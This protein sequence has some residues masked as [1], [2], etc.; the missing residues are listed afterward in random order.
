MLIPAGGVA[1]DAYSAARQPILPAMG[2]LLPAGSLATDNRLGF[3]PDLRALAEAAER[4]ELAWIP[5]VETSGARSAD[6]PHASLPFRYL[7]DGRTIPSW[8]AHAA[9]IRGTNPRQGW[10][11]LPS[12]ATFVD[13]DSPSAEWSAELVVEH[14]DG[15]GRLA[16][17]FP[18]T[19]TGR[20]LRD[21]VRLMAALPS[22]RL[23]I[24]CVVSGF[25][26]HRDQ[27]DRESVLFAEVS[28][29]VI[30][31]QQG[32]REINAA[33]RAI[34][35]SDTECNRSLRV[36]AAGGTDHG[37]AAHQFVVGQPVKARNLGS[38]TVEGALGSAPEV[39]RGGGWMPAWSRSTYIGE[40]SSWLGLQGT[41]TERIGF[42]G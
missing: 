20:Q 13:L 1:L 9:G 23:V 40:V 18:D 19:S 3:H 42:L 17:G 11:S 27:R 36:N 32:L 29:A 21:A 28:N 5:R 24:S 2:C 25:D 6:S 16:T 7:P 10:G 22:R 26:T 31:F 14:L 35:F 15:A 39:T 30:A 34:L 37:L 4:D 12:S 33:H 8:A 41:A 38:V